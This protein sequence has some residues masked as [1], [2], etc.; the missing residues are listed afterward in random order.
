MY[1]KRIQLKNI[2][3]FDDLDLYVTD[4]DGNLRMRTLVIGRN[5]TCKTTLLRSIALGLENRAD[6]NAL[7]AEP[8]AGQL[9]SP[10]GGESTITIQLQDGSEK[11]KFIVDDNGVEV[12]LEP[13]TASDNPP[14]IFLCGYGVGRANEGVEFRREYRIA[15]SAYTLFSYGA[16]LVQAE[17][18]LRRLRDYLQIRRFRRALEGI[19]KGMGLSPEGFAGEAA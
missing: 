6:V 2:R 8:L 5:G 11:Q 19:K 12:I 7:A 18:V 13:E 14:A 15:D 17:L 16:T 9:R 3:G 10:G 4:E 1:I